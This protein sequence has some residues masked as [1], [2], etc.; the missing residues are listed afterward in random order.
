MQ[1]CVAGIWAWAARSMLGVAD[2]QVAGG[3]VV[4]EPADDSHERCHRP[5]GGEERQL[6]E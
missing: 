2:L 6:I 3:R 4:P 1:T 5:D